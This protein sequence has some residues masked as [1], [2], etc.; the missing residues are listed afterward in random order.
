MG[1]ICSESI[2]GPLAQSILTG[3]HET[4]TRNPISLH[5]KV[6][7]PVVAP[8]ISVCLPSG[9]VCNQKYSHSSK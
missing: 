5:D 4:D 7:D 3:S 6:Y 9:L 1:P 2:T 8:L